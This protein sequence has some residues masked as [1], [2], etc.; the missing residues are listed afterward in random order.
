MRDFAVRAIK[1]QPGDYLHDVGR[2]FAL[3]FT[4]VD[5][6]DHYEMSTSVKWKL[7]EIVPYERRSP[8]MS[9]AFDTRLG[10]VPEPRQPLADVLGWYGRIV[11][12]PGPLALVLAVLAAAGI[13]VRRRDEA[14]RSARWW[15]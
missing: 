12:L 6:N 8:W 15:C 1:A 10:H 5:R 13:V 11:F 7:Q 14:R 3:A 2:D 4:A 9:Y